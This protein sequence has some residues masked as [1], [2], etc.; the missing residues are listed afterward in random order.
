MMVSMPELEHEIKS[1]LLF[2]RHVRRGQGLYLPKP[3]SS[4]G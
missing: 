2:S 4:D 1:V 3:Q